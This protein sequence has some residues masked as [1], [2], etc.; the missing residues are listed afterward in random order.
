MREIRLDTGHIQNRNPAVAVH[1]GELRLQF[2]E[3]N[4]LNRRLLSQSSVVY[5]N[6]SVE[7]NVAVQLDGQAVDIGDIQLDIQNSVV[8][9]ELKVVNSG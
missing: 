5:V 1:I 6:Y 4:K 2:A 8:K 3:L 7:V 9:N